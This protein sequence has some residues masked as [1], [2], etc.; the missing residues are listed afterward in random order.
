MDGSELRA[1]VL[2]IIDQLLRDFP[3]SYLQSGAVLQRAHSKLGINNLD[4]EQAL[5][6][7][8]Y[9][10]FRTGYLSWGFNLSNPSPPFFHVTGLG[11]KALAQ[12]S[13]D[14]A[15]PNGYLA[16]LNATA[17]IGPVTE[18]YIVE[19]LRTF[20]SGCFKAA[21]VMVGAAAESIVLDIRDVLVKKLQTAKALVPKSLTD[22]RL[23]PILEGI[24]EVIIAKKAN[25]PKALFERFEANWPAF[26]HQIRTARNDAGHP[27]NMDPVT[28]EQV[29]GSLLIFPQL[30]SLSAE[31]KVWIQANSFEP[32]L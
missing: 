14:P 26:T 22:W 13:R 21:A 27:I 23:K 24:E 4:D 29:H 28:A 1:A 31:L 15:N 25:V 18:S 7:F 30:A 8:F 12:H 6:A 10:L 9:D 17:G 5:L 32:R 3:T 16:H 20:N 19:G 2:Q 11:R